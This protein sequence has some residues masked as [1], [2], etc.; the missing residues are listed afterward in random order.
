M[1]GDEAKAAIERGIRDPEVRRNAAAIYAKSSKAALENEHSRKT[2][3]RVSDAGR[4][5]RELWAE[6]NGF[7]DIPVD[8]ATQ[9][10][11]FD[12]GTLY[13]AWLAAVLKATLESEGGYF[14]ALE[15]ELAR[16]GV[17]GHAD[18]LVY[19]DNGSSLSPD[20]AIDFK[21]TYG[22]WNNEEPGAKRPYQV[23]QVTNYADAAKFPRATVIT[24]APASQP[25][26]NRMRA[27]DYDPA[28]WL[29]RV[30][31]EYT[32]LRG[33]LETM[34]P[35]GDP[36]APWRCVSCRYSTCPANKNPEARVVGVER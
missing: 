31:D 1:T 4:C 11:R 6:I 12:L 21:S 10:T 8:L 16:Q 33:A 34:R 26:S 32:R 18:A 9:L 20:L 13:G 2:P 17:V 5:V 7:Q 25:A 19:V 35:D 14:V 28:E 24:I 30:D 22:K 15:M 27:D 3:I 29:P 23:I 36:D